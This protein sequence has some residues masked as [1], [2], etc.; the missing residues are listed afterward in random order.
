M[1]GQAQL[2]GDLK[3]ADIDKFCMLEIDA[4]ETLE[5]AIERFGLSYRSIANIKKVSRTIADL[6]GHKD[7][8]KKDLLE[9]L[10]FRKRD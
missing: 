2:N 8:T 7:I 1:R 6:N 4:K 10:S 9:A 3:E 5:L